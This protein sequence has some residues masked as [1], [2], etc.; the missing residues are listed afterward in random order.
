MKTST[1]RNVILDLGDIEIGFVADGKTGAIIQPPKVM[2]KE[3]GWTAETFERI[4]RALAD[5]RREHN[6]YRSTCADHGYLE[7][8]SYRCAKCDP[9][10]ARADAD[11][12]QAAADAHSPPTPT[13]EGAAL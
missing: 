1:T 2:S 5:Y 4:A 6:D 9:A 13:E 10:G 7:P 12:E 3:A 11:A 8:H